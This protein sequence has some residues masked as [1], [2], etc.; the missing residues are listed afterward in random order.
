LKKRRLGILAMLAAFLLLSTG[1]VVK[2]NAEFI[3]G[4][5]NGIYEAGGFTYRHYNSGYPYATDYEKSEG[6]DSYYD[7]VKCDGSI[8]GELK[9]PSLFL[10]HPVYRFCGVS[11]CAGLTKID[12]SNFNRTSHPLTIPAGGFSG[13]TGLTTMTIPNCVL[14]LGSGAFAGCS[15]LRSVIFEYGLS[16]FEDSLFKNCICLTSV[17]I[18]TSVTS[19][20]QNVFENCIKLRY[21][22]YC[23]TPEQWEQVAIGSGNEELESATVLFK[24]DPEPLCLYY[25]N[26]NGE[27]VITGCDPSAAG[28]LV[29]PEFLEWYPVTAIDDNAFSGCSELT[30]V[31]LPE[32]VTRIGNHAFSDCT[33][34]TELVLPDSVTEIGNGA[35]FNCSSLTEMILPDGV[36]EIKSCTFYDCSSLTGIDLPDGMTCIWDSA[37]ENCSALTEI[38][39]PDGVTGIKDCAFSHCSSLTEIDFPD[40]VTF[41]AGNIFNNCDSLTSVYLGR[42]VTNIDFCAF[43]YCD[44]L[45]NIYYNGTRERWKQIEIIEG[46]DSIRYAAI[47]YLPTGE[48]DGPAPEGLW[49]EVV[50]GEVI[51]TGY[52]SEAPGE[53]VIPDN[54]WGDPVTAIGEYA[55]CENTALSSVV[56]PDSVT[57]IG[58]GAFQQCT[59]L[60][61]INIPGS[62][63]YIGEYAFAGCAE[64]SAVTIEN[65]VETIGMDAFQNCSSLTSITIPDSVTEIGQWA[66]NGCTSLT[67]VIIGDGVIVIGNNAFRECVSM[68][69]VTIGNSVEIIERGVFSLCTGLTSVTFPD[70]VI[71][72]GNG[73]FY[74]CES[75]ETVTIGG[76]MSYIGDGAFTGCSALTDVYYNGTQDQFGQVYIAPFNEFMLD[77]NLHLQYVP[78]E[79]DCDHAYDLWEVTVQP[80]FSGIGWMETSCSLCGEVVHKIIPAAYAWITQWN[81]TVEDDFRL[82]F[83]LEISQSIES[84]AKVKIIIGD[85]VETIP[86]AALDRAE[87]FT[88]IATAKIS[89]AQMNESIVVIVMNG[90]EIG[91]ANT[92]SAHQYCN[93]ILADEAY[94]QYHTIVK[95]MLNYGAMAQMYFN[96]DTEN[97]A[98]DSIEDAAKIEV[99]DTAE[100]ISVSDD[101]ENLDFYGASLVFRDRIAVRYYFTG[102]VSGCTFNANDITYEPIEKD[103]MYYV[104]IADILPQDL[105]QSITLSVTDSEGNTLSVTY[106]PMNYIVR[107]NQKGSHMLQ[108]LVKALYNYHLAS[109]ELAMAA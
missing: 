79:D 46:N 50:D 14:A 86:V 85:Q 11:G 62:I 61:Q 40:G 6:L 41:I 72:M 42:G 44:N 17:T 30:S 27:A 34:L 54:I 29:I 103:G 48:V 83:C 63:S 2:T 38:D 70:S 71:E 76:S 69:S 58:N 19:I 52:D 95:E 93:T 49:Y 33:G 104:E 18:P 106:S 108:N 90:G 97:L 67:S 55:F 105:D 68:N 87:D 9:I 36:T 88:Y 56:I 107:M 21:I 43:L 66:F 89:A 15:G 22:Y 53:L 102:D 16:R 8:A 57:S 92:Y 28:E 59:G 99:P 4:I 26:R 80:S 23:G 101:I 73:T 25:E 7:I 3:G 91:F 84:T 81:I 98:N 75:L 60:T 96:Y 100:A 78:G 31:I 35:F 24:N 1:L 37:F 77:A 65:G 94:S 20:G 109:K 64:L 74:G 10:G 47:H 82:N 5:D 51:I 32:T 13:C 45:T 12:F 39:I